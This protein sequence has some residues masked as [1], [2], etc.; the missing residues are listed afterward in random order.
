M[1]VLRVG[2]STEADET[3][4]VEAYRLSA[5]P[6]VKTVDLDICLLKTTFRLHFAAQAVRLPTWR[7]EVWGHP[8]AVRPGALAG[9]QIKQTEDTGFETSTKPHG[10]LGRIKGLFDKFRK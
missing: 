6:L 9:R 2:P 3:V 8:G 4:S 10:I 1:A 7:H 5:V